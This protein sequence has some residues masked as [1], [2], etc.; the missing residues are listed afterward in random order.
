MSRPPEPER[1]VG[2]RW[3]TWLRPHE[4]GDGLP[5]LRILLVWDNLAGHLSPDMM[6][7]LFEQGIM[8]LYTPLGGS[9]L[10][11]AESMQRII[12]RRALSGQ[13]PPTVQEIITWLEQTVAGCNAD[14]TPFTWGGKRKERR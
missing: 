6:G 10:N 14:P 12:V 3:R 1:P 7:W 11:M 9:W 5:P 13:H 4:R 2:A 8:P